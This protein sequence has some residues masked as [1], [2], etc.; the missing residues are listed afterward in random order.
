MRGK[1]ESVNQV[2]KP[3]KHVVWKDCEYF[4]GLEDQVQ[5]GNEV[6]K[7]NQSLKAGPMHV[8]FIPQ[9]VGPGKEKPRHKRSQ[10]S[11]GGKIWRQKIVGRRGP[12]TCSFPTVLPTV[13]P[14]VF[15]QKRL[16]R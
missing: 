13:F 11:E 3:E 8:N 10:I 14:A 7:L 16:L 9:A 6:G 4:E 15:K 1:E 12:L 5:E 2:W